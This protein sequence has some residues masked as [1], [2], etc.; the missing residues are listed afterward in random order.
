[1]VRLRFCLILL[2]LTLGVPAVGGANHR[3]FGCQGSACAAASTEGDGA[4]V[5]WPG[6]HLEVGRHAGKFAPGGSSIQDFSGSWMNINL[7]DQATGQPYFNCWRPLPVGAFTWNPD[8]TATLA[9]TADPSCQASVMWTP[10]V[11]AETFVHWH[12]DGSTNPSSG[13]ASVSATLYLAQRALAS[14]FAGGPNPL[15]IGND[16][17]DA[18]THR[19]LGA[20]A[21]NLGCGF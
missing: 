18:E 21:T 2:V 7:W 10:P 13:S 11:D 9:Y 3:G 16:R 1:M 19:R 14:G 6:G 15:V 4:W 12:T 17:Q 5:N 8:G 20:C